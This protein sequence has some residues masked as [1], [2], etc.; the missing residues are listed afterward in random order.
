VKN[1][2]V[3]LFVLS[4]CAPAF[5]PQ[6]FSYSDHIYRISS[7]SEGKMRVSNSLSDQCTVISTSARKV[8][9]E[10]GFEYMGTYEGNFLGSSLDTIEYLNYAIPRSTPIIQSSIPQF[11]S[12]KPLEYGYS[13]G[14]PLDFRDGLGLMLAY[15]IDEKH[16]EL[17]GSRICFSY[18]FKYS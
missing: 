2:L 15:V 11:S 14:Y 5:Q 9:I 16:S 10:N 3:L 18:S 17:S 7:L 12:W 6:N 8:A 13:R 1:A 4:G